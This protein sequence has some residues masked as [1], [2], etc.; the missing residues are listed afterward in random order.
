MI[1]TGHDTHSQKVNTDIP[2]ARAIFDS[3]S[4]GS[5]SFHSWPGSSLRSRNINQWIAKLTSTP[6][7]VLLTD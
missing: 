3:G 1:H 7:T 6:T 2:T 5:P 4:A